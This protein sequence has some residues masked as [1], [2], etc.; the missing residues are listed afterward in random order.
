MTHAGNNSIS[1]SARPGRL[2]LYCLTAWLAAFSPAPA[3]AE[4][5]KPPPL[6][7]EIEGMDP[8]DQSH[9]GSTLPLNLNFRDDQGRSVTL[10]DYFDGKRPV[11][12]T[13]NFYTCTALCDHQLNGLT[14]AL[15]A[16]KWTPGDQFQ[17]V[18]VSFDPLERVET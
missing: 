5:D 15:K 16:L 3:R 2:G 7:P 18:T 14:D 6:P 4:D 8:G 17:I 1:R 10:G 13:L 11:L 9:L 12:L